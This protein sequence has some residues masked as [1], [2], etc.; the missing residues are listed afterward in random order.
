M[1][2]DNQI[3][4]TQSPNFDSLVDKIV[5]LVS[6]TKTKIVAQINDALVITNWHIG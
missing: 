5:R 1:T 4:L 6:D 3:Y 2:T